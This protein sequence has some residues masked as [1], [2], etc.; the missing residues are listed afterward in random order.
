M[1][2]LMQDPEI[3]E[4]HATINRLTVAIDNYV[5]ANYTAGEGYEDDKW[6]ATKVVGNT[7]V[8]D[9]GALF[10]ILPRGIFK[11]ITKIVVDPQA[12]DEAVRAG[13]ITDEQIASA[14]STRPNKPYVKVTARSGASNTAEAD[15]LAAKL[16]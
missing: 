10:K 2:D 1:L 16:A 8:W 6:L 14:L 7:R 3:V 9:A 11:Q 5:L 4:A 13:K 12:I 15:N